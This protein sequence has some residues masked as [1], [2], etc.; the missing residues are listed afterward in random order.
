MSSTKTT[1]KPA[2]QQTE[3]EAPA[4]K[5]KFVFQHYQD[6]TGPIDMSRIDELLAD[7]FDQSEWQFGWI[8]FNKLDWAQKRYYQI[9]RRD[10]HEHWFK[11]EAFD[12]VHNVIGRGQGNLNLSMGG[13][14]EVYLCVRPKEAA[15]EEQR[16]MSEY[17]ARR[18]Q[19][20]PKLAE[21]KERMGHVVGPESI[22]GGV[23]TNRSGWGQDTRTKQ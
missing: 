12:P 18:L 20:D 15:E 4:A 10:T 19:D 6:N 23:Q 16:Q 3:T 7:G 22:F 8:H 21:I 5:P 17:S 14:P 13:I 1:T 11:P 9:I 2:P